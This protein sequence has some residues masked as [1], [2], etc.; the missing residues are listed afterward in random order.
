MKGFGE[1]ATS[2]TSFPAPMAGKTYATPA[3]AGSAA[4]RENGRKGRRMANEPQ[5]GTLITPAITLDAKDLY[6]PEALRLIA[7]KV[8]GFDPRRADELER[9]AKTFETWRQAYIRR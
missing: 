7:R 2:S 9:T 6:A 1:S 8:R 5:S 4:E 3:F